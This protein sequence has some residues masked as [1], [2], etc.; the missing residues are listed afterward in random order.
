[1]KPTL[2]FLCQPPNIFGRAE[3][4]IMQPSNRVG[5]CRLRYPGPLAGIP[6][7]IVPAFDSLVLDARH[8][9]AEW[10]QP[11]RDHTPAT[12]TLGS[13]AEDFISFSVVTPAFG[14]GASDQETC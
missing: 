14:G 2:S 1:M 13:A 8:G 11:D 12:R 7:G 10:W 6:T 3:K 5:R 4:V 9:A